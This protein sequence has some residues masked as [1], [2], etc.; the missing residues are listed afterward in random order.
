MSLY[1]QMVGRVLRLA[2]GKADALI[3]DHAGAIFEHG[4][5]DESVNWTLA[6]DK[7]AENPTQI[8]RSLHEMPQLTNCPECSAVRV[9]G[10]P[11][12]VCGWRPQPKGQA[13]DV[14][15]GELG[16]VGRDKSVKGKI[17]SAAEKQTVLPGVAGV[18][19]AEGPPGRL[20]RS[21]GE[22]KIRHMAGD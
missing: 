12:G 3:L 10:Q 4:F 16:E 18:R 14:A 15:D 7:R 21:Q 22:G 13:V 9:G 17:P 8:S 5:I 11:C 19:A 1:R 2:D 20:G 6:P